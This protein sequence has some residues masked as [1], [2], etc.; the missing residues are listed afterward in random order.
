M[1]LHHRRPEHHRDQIQRPVI[2]DNRDLV[3]LPTRRSFSPIRI[4][5]LG[6]PNFNNKMRNVTSQRDRVALHSH[7]P[8]L[9]LIMIEKAYFPLLDYSGTNFPV[10]FVEYHTRLSGAMIFK[11]PNR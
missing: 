5:S 2:I 3:I 8:E 7:F 11:I 9:Y 4:I 10:S 6:F 1:K